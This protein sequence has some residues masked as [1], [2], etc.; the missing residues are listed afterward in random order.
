[1]NSYAL[2]N[3]LSD[4]KRFKKKVG[5]ALDQVRNLVG[6]GLFTVSIVIMMHISLAT[7]SFQAHNEEPNW[8][9]ARE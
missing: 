2:V 4:E 7:D 8:G 1:M 6:D 3:E 9:I 5:S